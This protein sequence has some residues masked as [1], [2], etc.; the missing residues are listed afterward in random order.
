MTD[1]S[2]SYLDFDEFGLKEV[3]CMKCN[4]PV[5][6]R[7]FTEVGGQKVMAMRRLS[8]W[9]QVRIELSNRTF[10]EPIFCVECAT[11]IDPEKALKQIK[12]GWE[13]E[14]REVKKANADEIKEHFKKYEKLTIKGKKE[15]EK[16]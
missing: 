8:S 9:K 12:K 4:T 1:Y 5:A 11:N 14:L 10:A 2:N 15:K 7:D 16:E 6:M 3:R 13:Q